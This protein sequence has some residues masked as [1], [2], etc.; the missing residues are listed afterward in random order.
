MDLQD[1]LA[2]TNIWQSDHDLTVKSARAQQRRIQYVRSVGC[3]NHNDPIIQLK[4][5]H[6]DQQLVQRL[7]AL[8]VTAAQTSATMAPYRVDFV[9]KNDTRRLLLGLLEHVADT[10]RAHADKHFD[11]IGA[12]DRE[13]RHFSFTRDRLGQ[14]RLTRSRLPY[15][16]HATGNTTAQL[17]E[18]T[19]IAQKLDQLLHVLLCLFNACHIGKRRGDLILSQ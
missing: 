12:G 17:L 14:Q 5:V 10:G 4:A 11:K 13:E 6:F 15:H 2:P 1:L 9:D 16:Q 3:G 18:T 8:V 19:G 7:L